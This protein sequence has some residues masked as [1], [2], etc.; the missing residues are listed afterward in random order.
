ME[1]FYGKIGDE[2]LFLFDAEESAHMVKVLRHKAGDR[3]YAMDGGGSLYSVELQECSPK[4]SAGR[5]VAVEKDWDRR[6]YTIEL[7]VCPTKNNERFEWMG[8]KV[9]E[10]GIDALVPVIGERSERK[11]YKT[12]RMRRILLSAAK[13]SLKTRIPQVQEPMS[14][15]EFI[16]RAPKNA[17]KL[18]A[19]CFEGEKLSIRDALERS[20]CFDVVILIGPEGD[21][22]PK[23][24]AAA[25]K[26]G[27]K[28]VHLGP[29]RLRT[30]TAALCAVMSVYN[31]YM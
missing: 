22:S 3:V 13:Q 18:I 24:V 29:S 21:F 17:L 16:E 2:N 12:E 19:Y 30:E 25:L 11:V 26:A 27:F 28:A 8:E 1:L 20:S 23:E 9:T 5:I 31:K 10:V 15:L 6:D 7:A 14:V 4:G